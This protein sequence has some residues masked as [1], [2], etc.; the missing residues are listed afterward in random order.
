LASHRPFPS[1]P[2]GYARIKVIPVLLPGELHQPGFIPPDERRELAAYLTGLQPIWEQRYS[3][4][5]PPPEGQPAR[6]LLRPVYWLGTWQFACLDYYRPPH[7]LK[8][9]VIQAEPFAPVL[10]RLVARIEAETAK[11]FSG[12]DLP[13]GWKLNTC[14]VNYYGTRLEGG[15]RVDVARVGEHR[16]FEPGPVA[17]LS[18]GERALFQF[19]S[20]KRPGQRDGVASQSWLADGDLQIFGGTRC[21]KE[22]FHRVQRVETKGGHRFDVKVPGFEVRRINLTLRWVPDADILPYRNLPPDDRAD[23]RGYMAELAKASPFFARALAA[24]TP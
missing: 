20:S 9:R 21:K 6:G 2:R 23:V 24:E 18:L 3:A 15:K 4:H 16:D 14:L 7:G 5:H 10:A 22:L 19:V 11:Q 17:S 12:A 8:N 13:R 1:K